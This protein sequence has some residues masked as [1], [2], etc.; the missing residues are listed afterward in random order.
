[1]KL[2]IRRDAII[3]LPESPQ[4]DSFIEDTLG[5]KQNGAKLEVERINEVTMGYT[6]NDRFVLK[7][8]K[9]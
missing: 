9:I 1:M 6:Q 4:D 3:I 8:K 7:I 5:F 2:E